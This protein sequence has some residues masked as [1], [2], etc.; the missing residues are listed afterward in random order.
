MLGKR[1]Y[2]TSMLN[3]FRLI[4]LLI[5]IFFLNDFYL[6]TFTY[7]KFQIEA[8]FKIIDVF[9][10]HYRYPFEF[11]TFFSLF[12]TPSIYYA[13]IRGVAF[14]EKGF[15][16]NKGLPFLSKTI[17]YSEVTGYKLLHPQ[18]AISISTKSGEVFVIADN[19][20]ERVIAILDQ[21]NIPGDLARDEYTRLISNYRKFIFIVLGFTA[22]L[23]VL[24]KI[25]IFLG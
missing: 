17:L 20:M 22:F 3:I 1:L 13:F 19:S 10:Y 8:R 24:K 18:C 12:I 5:F 11:I 21:Q 15:I 9:N 4:V 7:Q 14:F 25:G 2:K 23:F 16:F 6:D